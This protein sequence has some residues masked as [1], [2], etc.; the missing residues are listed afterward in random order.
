M[1]NFLIEVDFYGH[2]DP[3]MSGV[4]ATAPPSDLRIYAGS[5]A[6]GYRLGKLEAPQAVIAGKMFSS[7]A[8]VLTRG[9]WAVFGTQN[10]IRTKQIFDEALRDAKS[11][12]A[13][14]IMFLISGYSAGGVSAI[15]LARHVNGSTNCTLLYI[16]LSDAAFEKGEHDSLVRTPAV[17]A[18]YPKNYYQT[19]GNFPDVDEQHVALPTFTNYPLDDQMS[20]DRNAMNAGTIDELHRQAVVIGN[21]RVKDDLTWCYDNF[22]R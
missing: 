13:S 16:G 18:R 3:R 9:Y 14:N 15:H 17:T 5:A 4:D 2:G 20:Y 21:R 10:V 11:R 19:L 12:N 22:G 7:R 6:W 1:P 8:N